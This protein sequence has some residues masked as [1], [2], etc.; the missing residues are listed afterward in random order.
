MP[1]P[2]GMEFCEE[3]QCEMLDCIHL[4]REAHLRRLRDAAWDKVM[5][6][7]KPGPKRMT[8]WE[9]LYEGREHWV[10]CWCGIRHEPP[11]CDSTLFGEESL[12]AAYNKL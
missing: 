7:S 8:L 5:K 6:K 9:F 1:L 10:S 4:R 2:D 11:V 12:E 3:C